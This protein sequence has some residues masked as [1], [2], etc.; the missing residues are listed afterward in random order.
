M[1]AAFI[2]GLVAG[3][4]GGGLGG[5]ALTARL[6]SRSVSL[7]CP[8]DETAPVIR[9]LPEPHRITPKENS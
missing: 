5:A 9:R 3:I 1:I 8:A 6:M 4:F 2:V 7:R